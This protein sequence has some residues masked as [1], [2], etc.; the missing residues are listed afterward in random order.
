MRIIKHMEVAGPEI[1]GVCEKAY[2]N[3]LFHPVRSDPG[4]HPV[5]CGRDNHG[6]HISAVIRFLTAVSLFHL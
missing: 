4:V 2:D 5:Q 1:Q 3:R 6:N